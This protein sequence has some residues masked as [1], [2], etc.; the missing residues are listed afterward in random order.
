MFPRAFRIA[1]LGGVDI[2]VDPTWLIIAA[3]VVWSFLTRFSVQ[4][5]SG[6]VALTM[7]VAAALGFFLSVLG[8][9]LAHAL[10]ARHRG[11]KVHGITLFLFGG[12]TEM[13][14]R[15]RQPRDEF[16]VAFVGPYTS[17]VLAAALGLIAA[18]IDEYVPALAEVAEVAGVLGWFNL[19]VAL[20]NLVPGAP[21][22]GGRV[23]RAML[24]KVTG[25]RHRAALMASRAGQ[26]VALLLGGVAFWLAVSNPNALFSALW[27]GFIGWFMFNAA[28]TEQLQARLLQVVEGHTA[29]ALVGGSPPTLAADVPLA[30]VDRQLTAT[31]EEHLYPVVASTL[32]GPEIVGAVTPT[33]IEQVDPFDRGFRTVR[34]VMTP[35]EELP[36]APKDA[37]LLDVVMQLQDHPILAI[38]EN[39]VVLGVVDRHRA[40]AAVRR[41][42]RL[43][44]SGGGQ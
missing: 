28:R 34:D 39:E 8:H 17:L 29:A 42:Q 41:L 10:E 38:V 24:W 30:S 25:D 31:P 40:D 3:L 2:R 12:V 36:S 23:L 18:G 21:L 43:S 32:A 37:P 6:G 9:E 7:A 11:L 33:E 35:A 19:A 20:F 13:D 22:D 26:G 4:G 5:R 1:R 16:T 27:F 15:T 14:F 44:T